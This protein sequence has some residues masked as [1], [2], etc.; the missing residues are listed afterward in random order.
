MFFAMTSS[1]E[2]LDCRVTF[3][4]SAITAFAAEP[5]MIYALNLF[6]LIPGKE[7][8]YRDYSVRAGKIIYRLGGKVVSAGEGPLREMHGDRT[9]RQM[10]VVEFPSLEIFE[11]FIDEAETQNIHPLR[12]NS[13]QDYIWTLYQPWDLRKW[14]NSGP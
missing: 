4:R 9:R 12:E 6:N 14:V 2:R 11:Q 10:I 13:T 5:A 3:Y 8:D 1:R 7:D